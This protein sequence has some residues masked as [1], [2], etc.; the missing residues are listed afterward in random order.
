M[1]VVGCTSRGIPRGRVIGVFRDWSDATW[2]I[3]A[4]ERAG[5]ERHAVRRR[6]LSVR[7]PAQV[8]RTAQKLCASI[9]R[10]DVGV[11]PLGA[12]LVAVVA[13]AAELGLVSRPG[14]GRVGTGVGAA[15]ATGGL[16]GASLGGA[17]G[18]LINWI[19]TGAATIR[20]TVACGDRCDLAARSWSRPRQRAHQRRPPVPKPP[21]GWLGRHAWVV[22][23][24]TRG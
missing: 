2:A 19:V 16:L 18:N 14:V 1:M 5:F 17:A 7:R 4:L 22:Q 20:V 13:I 12:A 23:A 8:F 24:S 15:A 9:N 10:L 21:L 11:A 3:E 6:V